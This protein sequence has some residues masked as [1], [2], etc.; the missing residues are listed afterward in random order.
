MQLSCVLHALCCLV[1]CLFAVYHVTEKGWTKVSGDDVTE[2]HFKYYP[3][4]EKHASYANP[5]I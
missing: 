4:H 3:E 5:V 1:C 2:L